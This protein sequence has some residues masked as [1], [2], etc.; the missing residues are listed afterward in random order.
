VLP[1]QTQEPQD[2]E[3]GHAIPTAIFIVAAPV[4]AA[5]A[6]AGGWAVGA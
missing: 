1:P 5:F 3:A 2:Q 6:G 4:A